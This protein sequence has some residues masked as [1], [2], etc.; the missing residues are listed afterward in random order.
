[1]VGIN[2]GESITWDL[3]IN[4]LSQHNVTEASTA[5][6]LREDHSNFIGSRQV[7]TSHICPTLYNQTQLRIKNDTQVGFPLRQLCEP[8]PGCEIQLDKWGYCLQH[9][10][11]RCNQ[12]HIQ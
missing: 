10:C 5:I 1:M 6:F 4:S 3:T 2:D 9:P 7:F 12:C 8:L 11:N